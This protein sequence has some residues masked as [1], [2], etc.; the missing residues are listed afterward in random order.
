LK[1]ISGK[2]QFLCSYLLKF[3]QRQFLAKPKGSHIV[4]LFDSEQD[5]IADSLNA[6]G[7][8][9]LARSQMGLLDGRSLRRMSSDSGQVDAH[10]D[11][12]NGLAVG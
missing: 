3:F 10:Q 1:I 11:A 2:T 5:G 6:I 4:A 9:I 8:K 7:G 12:E